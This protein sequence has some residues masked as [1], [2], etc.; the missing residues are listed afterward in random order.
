MIVMEHSERYFRIKLCS[1]IQ[2][3]MEGAMTLR[4]SG[5]E[6]IRNLRGYPAKTVADLRDLLAAGAA[7]EPDPHRK[8]FY[9]LSGG[10]RNYYIHLAPDGSVWLIASWQGRHPVVVEARSLLAASV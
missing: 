10:G 3:A 1:E 2:E 9:A 4:L 8:S 5:K 7:A 6:K